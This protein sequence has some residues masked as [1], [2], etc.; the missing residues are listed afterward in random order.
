MSGKWSPPF[1]PGNEVS[2]Y[3]TKDN[4]KIAL[5]QQDVSFENQSIGSGQDLLGQQDIDP[6]LNA[7]MHLVN[8]VR[9]PASANFHSSPNATSSCY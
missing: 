4:D 3:G 2:E 1:A 5:G 8:N 6:A 9:K 7:K